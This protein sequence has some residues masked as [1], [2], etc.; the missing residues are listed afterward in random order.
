MS[1]FAKK[2]RDARRRKYVSAQKFAEK[3]GMDPHAY[4]KY[5]RGETEPNF[6]TLLRMCEDLEVTTD[7]LL[8]LPAKQPPEAA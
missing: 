2:L 1:A 5:E 8:P 7:D 6:E 3:M 4:R